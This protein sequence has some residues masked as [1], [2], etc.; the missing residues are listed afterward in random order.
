MPTMFP[1]PATGGDDLNRRPQNPG[2]VTG[3]PTSLKWAFGIFLATAVLMVLTSLVMFTAGYTGPDAVDADYMDVVVGN[4]KF[5][6]GL[7]GLAGVVIAALISQVP[8]SGKNV[9]RLL[10]AI[11]LLVVLVD[12]LSFVTRAGGP[13]LAVIA[14]LLAFASLLL[15]RPAVSDLVEENHRVKKMG[16][17][18]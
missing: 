17:R 4:Q 11:S 16:K 7:N 12:L 8:R 18:D 13:A 14:V 2:E 10:L 6:G 15:F 5:I 3:I 9:R 1:T